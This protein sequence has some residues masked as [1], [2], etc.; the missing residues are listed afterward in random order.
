M[1]LVLV[2][3]PAKRVTVT[4]I[5][6]G[7]KEELEEAWAHIATHPDFECEYTDVTSKDA[8]RYLALVKA[9]AGSRE[10]R[11]TVRKLNRSAAK[12]NQVYFSIGEYDP[13]APKPGRKANQN[14]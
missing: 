13:N 1:G 11:L 3:S 9:W 5:P 10:P 2:P 4:E 12:E 6:V 7:M 14:G 8:A